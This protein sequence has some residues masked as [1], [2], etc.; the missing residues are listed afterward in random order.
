MRY[1]HRN[2]TRPFLFTTAAM[3]LCLAL[4]ACSA[5]P[6]ASTPPAEEITC[7]DRIRGLSVHDRE[8]ST[9]A[10]HKSQAAK[11]AQSSEQFV[12]VMLDSREDGEAFACGLTRSWVTEV[13]EGL[14][15]QYSESKYDDG[16]DGSKA[17]YRV[18]QGDELHGFFQSHAGSEETV[19]YHVRHT[20]TEDHVFTIEQLPRGQG[21]R[22]YQS[23]IGGYSLRAW[24][25]GS[26]DGLFEADT[27]EIMVWRGLQAAVNDSLA[28]IS[29]GQ[30]SLDNLDA[31]PAEWEFA[32]P[33]YEYVRDYGEGAIMA[34]FERAWERYGK[35]RVLT[36]AEFVDDYLVKLAKLEV[37]FRQNDHM[38][39]PFPEELWDTWIEL[40][41]SPNPLHFPGLPHDFI[42]DM[43]L[44]DRDY[45]LEILDVVLSADDEAVKAACAANA[46]ILDASIAEP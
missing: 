7:H 35:G 43:I 23:Y 4:V 39:D 20:G 8:L 6:D 38:S 32:R 13:F 1:M 19:I 9:R 25:S 5:P 12:A 3:Q 14:E 34:N 36:E 42:T 31:L 46:R 28:Q 2:T 11:D 15:R 10:D 33:Y 16:I 45:R 18:F 17:G 30:A 24:L 22:I 40:Y 21:Y 27:G 44:A 37:Y 29:G 26:T 41:A